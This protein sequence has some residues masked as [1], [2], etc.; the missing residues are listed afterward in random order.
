MNPKGYQYCVILQIIPG[1]STGVPCTILCRFVEEMRRF[2]LQFGKIK[3]FLMLFKL[4]SIKIVP[5]NFVF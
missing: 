1:F 2:W 3:L 5:P 4:F